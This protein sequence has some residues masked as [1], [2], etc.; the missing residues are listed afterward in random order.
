MKNQR[1]RVPAGFE[2]VP[3][4]EMD[5]LRIESVIQQ[6]PVRGLY[7]PAAGQLGRMTRRVGV[8]RPPRGDVHSAVVHSR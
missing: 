5:P 2:R 3:G 1:A 7:N 6:K 4:H 8:K